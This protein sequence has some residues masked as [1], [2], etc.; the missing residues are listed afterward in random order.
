MTSPQVRPRLGGQTKKQ[1]SRCVQ[2][3]GVAT[4]SPSVL[5]SQRRR[6]D[7]LDTDTFIRGMHPVGGS[8]RWLSNVH[9]RKTSLPPVIHPQPPRCHRH[10]APDGCRSG[11]SGRS[12]SP[13]AWRRPRHGARCLTSPP[14]LSLRGAV[15]V[16][17]AH[18]IRFPC[19]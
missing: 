10:S 3:L 2:Q 6:M 18:A 17:T 13:G 9:S 7:H 11:F 4:G 8:A 16:A 14:A 1:Q 12:Q 19:H 15:G 5:T